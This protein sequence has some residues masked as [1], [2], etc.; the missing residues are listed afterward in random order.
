MRHPGLDPGPLA[1]SLS[2]DRQR[3]RVEHGTTSAATR[4]LPARPRRSRRSSWPGGPCAGQIGRAR[5]SSSASTPAPVAPE[6]GNTLAAPAAVSSAAKPGDQ[7]GVGEV[8]LVERDQPRLFGQALAVGLELV[9]RPPASLRPGSAP[10]MSTRWI[11]TR[12]RSIWPRKRSP[13][14]APSAAPSISPGMSASTN[15]RPLVAH[16]AELGHAAW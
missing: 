15:S 8:D 3:S 7:L 14:P 16:D 4:V 6:I 10:A 13:M 2:S 12:Q 9:A 5:A 1:G 11:S